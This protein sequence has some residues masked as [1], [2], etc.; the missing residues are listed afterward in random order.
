VTGI[1]Y[2]TSDFGGTTLSGAGGSDV[3]M[4]QYSGSDGRLVTVKGIGSPDPDLGQGVAVDSF[5]N[6]FLAGFYYS[7]LTFDGSTLITKGSGDI[8]LAKFAR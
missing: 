2:G 6:G 7:T 3:F 5:G 4:A 8:F 1:Y